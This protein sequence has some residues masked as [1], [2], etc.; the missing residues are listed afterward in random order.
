MKQTS[1]SK[2]IPDAV[3]LSAELKSIAAGINLCFTIMK[4]W[5]NPQRPYDQPSAESL[6][7][8]LW[9]AEQHLL[10]VSED[11]LIYTEMLEERVRELSADQGE[12]GT[13]NV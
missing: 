8:M 12:E 4:E 5:D 6:A 7:E 13:G 3:D 1:I 2:A 9:G 10:R 11:W